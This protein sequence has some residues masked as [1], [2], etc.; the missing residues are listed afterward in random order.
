[1]STS[2]TRQRT[3]EVIV[4]P[5]TFEERRSLR[6]FVKRK[7]SEHA[8]RAQLVVYLSSAQALG[9]SMLGRIRMNNGIER[10]NRK[11]RKRTRIVGTF[12]DGNSALMLV[13]ARL[14]YIVKHEWGKRRY[15]DMSKL[16]EMDELRG[17]AEG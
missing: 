17:E 10:I 11:S 4:L 7:P 8:V 3:P 14:K 2:C 6:F 12:P 15:P 1:M 13:T 5:D 16:E 9:A